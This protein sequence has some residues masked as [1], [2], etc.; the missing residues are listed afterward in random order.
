MGEQNDKNNSLVWSSVLRVADPS[1]RANGFV[2]V[3]M[4]TRLIAGV[5]GLAALP[6]LVVTTGLNR[7]A[8]LV[9]I[10]GL[11]AQIG[12]AALAASEKI[13]FEL[14]YALSLAGFASAL[15]AFSGHMGLVVLTPAIIEAGLLLNR[16]FAFGTGAVLAA[17]LALSLIM[18]DGVTAIN[19]VGI[20]AF[21]SAFLLALV[22]TCIAVEAVLYRLN[23]SDLA[24]RRLQYVHDALVETAD[25]GFAFVDEKGLLSTPS[26]S[27]IM[28]TG[29]PA[30]ELSGQNFFDHVHVLSRPAY[31]KAVSDAFHHDEAVRATIKFKCRIEGDGDLFRDFDLVARVKPDDMLFAHKRAVISLGESK[32]VAEL[33]MPTRDKLYEAQ[34]RHELKTPLNAILG[35]AEILSNPAIVA[36]DDPRRHDYIRII[37]TSARHLVD[38]ID[39]MKATSGEDD[40]TLGTEAVEVEALVT[41]ALAMLTLSAE[42]RR[43]IIDRQI[44]DGLPALLGERHGLRQIIINLVSNAVKYSP[45]GRVVIAAERHPSGVHLSVSD[46][47]VGMAD[48][49]LLRVGEPYFRG[50]AGENGDTEGEGLGLAVVRRL[51]ERHG[52]ELQLESAPGNGTT[53]R[54]IFSHVRHETEITNIGFAA[55]LSELDAIDDGQSPMPVSLPQKA[56]GDRK[57][58]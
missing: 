32:A 38:L 13:R 48:Q 53:A 25:R 54:V 50:A 55:T 28:M 21:A 20:P 16:R 43:V 58:A 33:A 22:T 41:E 27:L 12:A 26:P 10:I 24:Y 44:E 4:M 8:W 19:P 34:L 29:R 49:E 42:E 46:D 47:G 11:A 7:T 23:E 40:Q 56:M 52:G 30:H 14:A 15:T 17:L 36:A 6:P 2:D 35:F 5:G 3:F 9:V 1:K 37:A 31:L 18:G 57:R 45:E 51:V 39:H